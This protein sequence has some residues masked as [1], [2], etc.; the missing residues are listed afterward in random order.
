MADLQAVKI[1]TRK[2]WGLGLVGVGLIF[3]LMP[4]Y[5]EMDGPQAVGPMLVL[6]GMLLGAGGLGFY[7]G[8]KER[9]P[10]WGIHLLSVW[11][12]LLL[13]FLPI[14]FPFLRIR[15]VRRDNQDLFGC[16]IPTDDVE[17]APT[18]GRA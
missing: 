7:A 14:R 12:N 8:L 4:F 6:T 1:R 11:L 17:W 15:F 9:S 5:L 13:A 16:Q 3:Q 2:W 10:F 18:I